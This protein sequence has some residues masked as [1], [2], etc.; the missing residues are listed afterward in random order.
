VPKMIDDIK[1][2]FGVRDDGADGADHA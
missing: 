2:L 1:S